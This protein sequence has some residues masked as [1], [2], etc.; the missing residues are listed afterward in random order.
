MKDLADVKAAGRLA[1]D[2]SEALQSFLGD[3]MRN[4]TPLH[5]G[6]EVWLTTTDDYSDDLDAVSPGI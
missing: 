6:P 2:Q 3:L 1:L 5:C 4:Q